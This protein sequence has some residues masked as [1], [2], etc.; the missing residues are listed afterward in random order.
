MLQNIVGGLDGSLVAPDELALPYVEA[1]DSSA[2]LPGNSLTF[3]GYPDTGLS[4]VSTIAGQVSGIT[5]ERSGSSQAW[6][7]TDV[8]LPGVFSGGGAYDANGL[9]IGVPTSASPTDGRSPGP[10]CLLLQDSTG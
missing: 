1:G 6:L 3:V 10:D 2:I 9:L 8:P 7:R 5:A 4:S